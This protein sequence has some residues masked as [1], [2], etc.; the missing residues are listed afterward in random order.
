M[1]SSKNRAQFGA[2]YFTRTA[3]AYTNICVNVPPEAVYL[4]NDS[5][6]TQMNGQNLYAITFARG[7]LPLVKGF[8][9]LTL[10]NDRHLFNANPLQRHSLGT[11]NK[12]LQYN[13]DGSLTLYAGVTSPGEDKEAKWLPAPNGTFSLYLR[14]YWAD[15]ARLDG[16][17]TPPKIER[18]K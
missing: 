16:N 2:D 6:G 14:G 3:T 10:Y 9:S 11:K 17:W 15:K 12:T 4:Y 13:A 7:Q 8:C 1:P 5:S 18:L